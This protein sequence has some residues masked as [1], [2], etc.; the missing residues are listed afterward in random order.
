MLAFLYMPGSPVELT[1]GGKTY[2]VVASE[3]E[4]VLKRLA[5]LVDAKLHALAAPG[6]P[7]APQALLLA[8]MALAHDLEEERARRRQVEARAREMLTTVLQRIDRAIEEADDA[9]RP[10]AGDATEAPTQTESDRPHP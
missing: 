10:E 3:E 8:A 1:V 6:R 9:I 2:R 7:I 4:L 5:A